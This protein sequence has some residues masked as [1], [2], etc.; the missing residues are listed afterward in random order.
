MTFQA[1][2]NCDA[3]VW[4]E[5]VSRH[6]A[7]HFM[8]S[9]AWG[10]F[11]A[12]LG[13][14][15][16]YCW[17]EEGGKRRAAALLLARSVPGTGT[18]VF[19][20]ARGPVVD[21]DDPSTSDALFQALADYLREQRGTFLRCDPYWREADEVRDAFS[22]PFLTRVPRDWSNWNAPRFVFWLDLQG[23]QDAVM[24][25]ATSRCRNDI[26]RGYRNDVAFELGSQRDLEE[27]YRLMVL[28]GQHKGI[29]FH[30]KDY[31]RR[32]HEM[33]SPSARVQ[34][35]LGKIESEVITTGISVVYGKRAWLL[36]AASDPR[37]YKLRANRTLQWEMIKWAH[38]HGCTRYDFR[39]TATSDPPS[40]DDPGYGV[41]Q[42][43][44]SF[45]PEFTRLIGYYDLV[46]R[47]LMYR[48]LRIAEEYLLPV[49]YKARVWL[50]R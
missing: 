28:T 36:Y 4:D 24:A 17:L 7:G 49:A 35:F 18:K 14:E 38:G 50:A 1:Q 12:E 40:P 27:F 19:Y 48:G 15:P 31:Y 44:K 9:Y 37:S 42:F 5:F 30:G 32:L 11:Q 26:R 29:A 10:Q 20:A 13:W 43:K 41:Y 16:H 23:D 25:R 8:Q 46:D 2:A 6:V 39:G 47:A 45:G 21:F 34:V 33:V 22:S 3:S